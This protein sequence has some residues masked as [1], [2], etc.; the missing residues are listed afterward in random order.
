M[1]L[2]LAGCHVSQGPGGRAGD[3]GGQ[4]GRER[5][6][7]TVLGAATGPSEDHQLKTFLRDSLP[8][9]PDYAN[10]EVIVSASD[11]LRAWN[12]GAVPLRKLLV[13]GHGVEQISRRRLRQEDGY[14][15]T[16]HL[17]HLSPIAEEHRAGHGEV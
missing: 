17:V 7:R 8:R 14:A 11:D 13:D 4:G 9:V 15:H 3:L 2:P 16:R 6:K 10:S 1:P 12:W 5:A